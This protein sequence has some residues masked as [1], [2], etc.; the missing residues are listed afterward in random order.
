M[1]K[2]KHIQCNTLPAELEPNAIYFVRGE[3]KIVQTDGDANP[4]VFCLQP[5][6]FP[7]FRSLMEATLQLGA[8]HFFLW[9]EDNMDGVPS[10]N[11]TNLGITKKH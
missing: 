11:G 6:S 9:A 5:D 7:V 3:Q 4:K 1:A 8:G 2:V 10:P